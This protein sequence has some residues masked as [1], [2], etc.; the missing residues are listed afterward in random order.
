MTQPPQYQGSSGPFVPQQPLPPQKNPNGKVWWIVG[1]CT[2]L[3]LLAAAVAIVV[4]LFFGGILA[5]LFSNTPGVDGDPEVTVHM[6][7]DALESEDCEAI[8]DTVTQD[9]A[10]ATDCTQ[11]AS[12]A[13]QYNSN[14]TVDYRIN[15]SSVSGDSA[16][17]NVTMSYNDPT[18]S[19]PIDAPLTFTLTKEGGRWLIDGMS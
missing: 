5:G 6:Y 1:G 12:Y 19:Q 17:V 8:K 15:D 11:F 7:M 2:C 18:L 16:T 9:L 3:T 14:G 4:V 10:D 13:Q